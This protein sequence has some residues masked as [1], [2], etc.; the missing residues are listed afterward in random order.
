MLLDHHQLRWARRDKI[1][2]L[3]REPAILSLVV[4][5]YRH[6]LGVD[7]GNDAVRFSG[8]KCV[9]KPSRF[10]TITGNEAA[11]RASGVRRCTHSRME[12]DS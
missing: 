5:D 8:Q 2:Q 4:Q 11:R 9:T 3:A 6:C 1:A 7:R 12:D 10:A